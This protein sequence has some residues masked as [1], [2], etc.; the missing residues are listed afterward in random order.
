[1]TAMGCS[2]VAGEAS[3]QENQLIPS[4]DS[5]VSALGTEE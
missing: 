2:M 4:K 5:G 1:M 3:V